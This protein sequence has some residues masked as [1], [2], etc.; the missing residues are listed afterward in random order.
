[1]SLPNLHLVVQSLYLNVCGP[2]ARLLD[3]QC[4]PADRS[5]EIGHLSPD[6]QASIVT[7]AGQ[8]QLI[9]REHPGLVLKG[10]I[11]E[12]AFKGKIFGPHSILMERSE[13]L[14]NPLGSS[15]Q[16][17]MVPSLVQLHSSSGI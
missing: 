10:E 13:I 4:L 9:P 17:L 11:Q 3:M 14:Q 15:R 6:E 5:T 7:S 8:H 12:L 1:M 2:Q 16:C